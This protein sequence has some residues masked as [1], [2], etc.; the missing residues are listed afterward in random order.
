MK[1]FSLRVHLQ[2]YSIKGRRQTTINHAFASAI[3]PNDGYDDLRIVEALR[4]LGQD[5]DS[6]LQCAYCGAH[7]EGWDHVVGLVRERRYSGYGHTLGNLLPFCRQCNSRKGNRDW[8]SFLR[9]LHP[10]ENLYQ[11]RLTRL[12]RYFRIFHQRTLDQ[13]EIEQLCPEE[14]LRLTA[15]RDEIISLMTQADETAAV[16]RAKVRDV[17][18]GVP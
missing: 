14:M 10:N 13:E 8:T 18:G 16:V 2:P 11:V 7:A 12:A 4:V 15:I 6:D 5:P 9:E 1:R 3:A 17:S